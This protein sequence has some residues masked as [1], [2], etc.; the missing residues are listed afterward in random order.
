[1]AG[2]YLTYLEK[3]HRRCVIITDNRKTLLSTNYKSVVVIY[4]LVF[5]YSLRFLE[6]SSCTHVQDDEDV[7]EMLLARWIIVSCLVSM[8]I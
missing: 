4:E 8:L 3:T 6:P 2:S 5:I 1:M 7:T